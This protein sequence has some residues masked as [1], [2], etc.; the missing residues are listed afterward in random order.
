MQSQ[1]ITL[2]QYQRN[3]Q[4]IKTSPLANS[5]P[6]PQTEYYQW[7]SVDF[8]SDLRALISHMLIAGSMAFQTSDPKDTVA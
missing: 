5:K 7:F 6:L 4:Y 8:R 1:A 3:A 2:M